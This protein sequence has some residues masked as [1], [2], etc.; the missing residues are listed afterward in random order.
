MGLLIK[1]EE[2]FANNEEIRVGLKKILLLRKKR[3]LNLL[4][5]M[6]LIEKMVSI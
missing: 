6:S 2:E 3:I 5:M 4:T 1:M